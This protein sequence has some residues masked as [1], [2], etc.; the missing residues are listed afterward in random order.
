MRRT[1]WFFPLALLGTLILGGGALLLLEVARIE[2][3]PI[4][5]Q[6]VTARSL[7]G[8]Y[9]PVEPTGVFYPEETFYLSV[10]VENVA[11][12]GILSAQ[13][14]YDGTPITLQDQVIGSGSAYVV[15][16]ELD[17]TDDLWPVGSYRVD[18]SLAGQPVGSISFQVERRPE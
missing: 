17:R 2:P 7:D 1:H 11:Q 3:E 4:R 13:W 5:I 10:R 14:T 18:L 9:Q 6:A 16:F 15:G 8:Q 12:P